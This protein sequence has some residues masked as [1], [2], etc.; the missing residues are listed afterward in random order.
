MPLIIH[1]GAVSVVASAT[2]KEG[3]EE[4]CLV[5]PGHLASGLCRCFNCTMLI[6]CPLSLHILS[7]LLNYPGG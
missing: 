4:G 1:L 7:H 5:W 6:L 3:Q 2:G